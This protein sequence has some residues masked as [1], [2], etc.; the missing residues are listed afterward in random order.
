MAI[1]DNAPF[2]V[3][4]DASEV[5][6]S[7][8]LNQSG[9]PVAFFSR[10]LS[11]SEAHYPAVEK[12]ALAIIE[13]IRKW[14]HLLIKQRFTLI[15][16]QKSVSFMLDNRKR[17]KIKNNKILGWR[18]ELAPF[19]YD[20][21]Y[22]PGKINVGPDTLTRAYCSAV[23]SGNLM[24]VHK[25]LGCPGVTRLFHF[26]KEKNL[27]YSLNDVKKTC[28]SCDICAELK[29]QF[30]SPPTNHLIEATKPMDRL[31]I[32]FKGP[33]PSASR[34]KYFLCIVDEYS[35]FPFCSPVMIWAQ[36]RLSNALIA[37]SSLT[38]L[39]AFSL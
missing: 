25:A 36:K 31:N 6:I 37:Y 8:T 3:E 27:P 1:D 12:E 32:D 39:V 28:G 10:T 16:D 17:T 38:S 14:S 22:R 23:S 19:S 26:V 11:K 18:L 20:I 29:P 9:R 21:Q 24:E 13:A 2:T 15:T 34:N 35:R 30:F 4:C 33:L 7:A 5:A